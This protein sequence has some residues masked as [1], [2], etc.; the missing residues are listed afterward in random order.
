MRNKYFDLIDQT[1]EWPQKEFDLDEDKTLMWNGVYL[2][3]IIKQYGTPLK[4]TYLPKISEQIQRAKRMFNVAMAK[5]G[6]EGAYN[7]CYCTKSSHFSFVLDEALKNGI[8]IET[9]KGILSVSPIKLI[10]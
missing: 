4:V 9:I 6:Y 2:M 7:Y 10:K 1:F 8:H 5:V 3:D